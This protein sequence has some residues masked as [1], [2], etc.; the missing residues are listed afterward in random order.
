MAKHKSGRA[1]KSSDSSALFK[2]PAIS[3]VIPLYNAEKYVG[4]CLDSLLAQ[5]F[6]NFEVIVVDD[7]STDNSVKVVESYAEKF[8][9][10]LTLTHMKKNSGNAGF[11]RN[12]GIEL[13]IGEYIFFLDPD[14]TITPTAF[15]ELYSVAKEFNADVVQCEKY[16]EI[17]EKFWNDAEFRKQLKPYSYQIGGFV[18]E[19]TLITEDF[20]ER[21]KDFRQVKFLHNVW[22]KLILRNFLI[23]DELTMTNTPGQDLFFTACVICSAKNFVRVPNVVNYY[24][25]RE[26]SISTEKMDIAR[27]FIKWLR[28]LKIGTAYIDKFLD[29]QKFFSNRKDL[30]YIIFDRILQDM[31]N[32][33]NDFYAQI[34]APAFDELLRKEFSDGDNTALTTFIFSTMNIYRLQLIQAHQRI[35]VL[36]KEV[37]RVK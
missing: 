27:L 33:W 4:E 29:G 24:R 21:I 25:I 9:G 12:K 2:C 3:V 36:E 32:Y 16:Y 11:P 31:S 7:C 17:P 20:A 13:S 6:Q 30:K 26:N 8:G 37:R 15:E 1:R 14:D 35:A 19:P 10:R 5:T 23:E 18:N 34:P 22:S 28:A